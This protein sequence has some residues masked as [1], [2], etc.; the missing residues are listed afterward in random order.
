LNR[1][2]DIARPQG[3]TA[4]QRAAL[5][6][7]ARHEPSLKRTALRFSLDE[8]DAEDAYQRAL[9]IVLTKAPTTDP[10]E[11]IRWTQTVTKHEALAVRRSRERLL[12][13]QPR[14]AAE[15]LLWDPL[16]LIPAGGDGP[17]EQVERR[18]EI[19]RSR[20]AL[21]TL[22]PAELRALG[23]LAEGYSYAEIG[24]MT[25]FS[26]TKINRLLA[27]GRSR[28]RD[29]ISK[30]EDGTRCRELR[31]LLS[32]FCDGEAGPG[33][34]ETVREH[35]RACAHCRATMRAYRAAPGLASVLAPTLPPS[36]SLLG[37]LHD[38]LARAGSQISG[39]AKLIAV[40][41]A[42][43]VGCVATGVLPI[44]HPSQAPPSRPAV[45][46]VTDEPAA[47]AH[48]TRP[49]P[50]ARR[51]KRRS[52]ASRPAPEADESAVEE[53]A[54]PEPVEYEPPP[55]EPV[56]TASSGSAAGEFGP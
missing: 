26:H 6:L 1:T 28:F 50:A 54:P 36:R 34:A 12:G 18:E 29:L 33:D 10:Q 52:Q 39:T 47:A 42:S 35:L 4:R 14:E 15:G 21:R 49:K 32:A 17:A 22:K 20:E 31:P 48:T 23:L 7:I 13:P 30:S 2:R 53:E 5:E 25:G 27:E 16:A 24:A 44:P 51:H 41:A 3:D 8:G 45:E 43:T 40:C 55:P 9:E 46:R 37:R 19:A 38:L 11:L 56:E